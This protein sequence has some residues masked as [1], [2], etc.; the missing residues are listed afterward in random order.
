M[1]FELNDEQTQLQDSVRR[2]L[3]SHGRFDQRRA[4]ACAALTDTEPGFSRALWRRLAELGVTA[5]TLPEAHG[6]YGR[7]AVD[8]MP[9]MQACGHA[10]LLKPLLASCVLG[11]TAVQHAADSATQQR[12]LPAVA[13]GEQLLAW[14]HDEAGAQHAAG[15][16]E[17]RATPQGSGW[18]LS[19]RKINVLHGAAAHHTVVSA[20]VGGQPGSSEALALFLVDA[21]ATGLQRRPTAWWTTPQRPN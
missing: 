18:A 16:V 2:L 20:R 19:G 15:W 1:N 8:L 4:T 21:G 13:A 9:V 12:L 3:A 5:L 7:G 6:G 10:P 17:T 14:A 11:A